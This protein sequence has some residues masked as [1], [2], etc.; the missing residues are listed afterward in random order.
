VPE[1]AIA[2]SNFLFSPPLEEEFLFEKISFFGHGLFG[3]SFFGHF[4]GG[5]FFGN[6]KGNS[7]ELVKFLV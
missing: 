6:K 2:G 3:I 4:L 5:D 7:L 1:K